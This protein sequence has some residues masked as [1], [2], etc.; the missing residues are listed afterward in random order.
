MAKD[1]DSGA[2]AP[3]SLTQF[4]IGNPQDNITSEIGLSA[5]FDAAGYK[6][7]IRPMRGDEYMQ[8]QKG[9][10]VM[11]KGG[12]FSFS[13]QKFQELIVLN[14]TLD[15]DFRSADN[16]K[17]SG[18]ATPEAFLYRSLNAGE[19]QTLFSGIMELSGIEAPE[20]MVE[21]VKNS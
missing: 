18:C 3:M 10:S 20:I 4:L 5:R 8:Y 12:K 11:S 15:P 2:G 19:I 21:E 6:F 17:A 1:I 7:K 13:N 9:A 14:C 16:I